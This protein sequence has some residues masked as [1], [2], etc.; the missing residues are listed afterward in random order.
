MRSVSTIVTVVVPISMAQPT[1]AVSSGPQISIHWNVLS[2]NSPLTQTLQL[3]S[4]RVEARFTM[5]AKGTSTFSTPVASWTAQ[6]SR[7]M[8][9]MVSSR[10]GSAIWSTRARKRLVNSMPLA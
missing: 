7:S 6:V 2:F 1:M 5:T 10:V 8:S 3:C 4:R 9:G